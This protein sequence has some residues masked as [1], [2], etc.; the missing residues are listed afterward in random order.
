MSLAP[1]ESKTFVFILAYIENPVEEKWIG[2]AEDGKINRTRAEALMKEFDTKEK[3]EAALAELKN[4]GMNCF[5]TLRY[6]L[7]RKNWIV[8]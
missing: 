4:T 6:P 8:W 3:S 5:L 7:P 1:G 2:R